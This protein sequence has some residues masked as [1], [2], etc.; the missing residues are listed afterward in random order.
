MQQI[1]T[2][3]RKW[4]NNSFFPRQVPGLLW[5]VMLTFFLKTLF[6]FKKIVCNVTDRFQAQKGPLFQNKCA[7]KSKN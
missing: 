6:F 5:S 4:L 7:R 1:K 2:T 3:A